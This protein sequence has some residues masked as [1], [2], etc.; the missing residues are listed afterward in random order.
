MTD[1]EKR[2]AQALVGIYK[3]V[4]MQQQ[5]ISILL[6]RGAAMKQ[7]LSSSSCSFEEEFEKNLKKNSTETGAKALALTLKAID[8]TISSLEKNFGPWEN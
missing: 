1:N 7:T 2:L 6:T 8:L 3:T 4:R 5:T